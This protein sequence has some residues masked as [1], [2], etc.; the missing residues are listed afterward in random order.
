MTVNK[1]GKLNP[2]DKEII[3]QSMMADAKEQFG[4]DLNDDEYAVIRFFYEPVAERHAELQTDLRDV[5]ESTQLRYATGGA[6]D[7]VCEKLGIK[8]RNALFSKGVT[9]FSRNTA[10]TVD[11]TIPSGTIIQTDSVDPYRF[12]TTSTAILPAGQTSVD[13]NIKAKNSGVKYNVGANT[14]T[15]M[16]SPPTGIESVT[17]PADTNDGTEK[18]TDTEL[19]RRVKKEL[20][21]GSRASQEALIRAARRVQG[22]ENASIFVN[23]QDPI[24]TVDG[25][26]PHEVEMV[27]EGGNSNEIAQAL[28]NT[29]AAGDILVG[30]VH[31]VEVAEAVSLSNGQTT[32]ISYSN[33]EKV[34]IY[35][36]VD[37]LV[38]NEFSDKNY[39]KDSIVS[40]IGGLFS[41]GNEDGG[42]LSVGDNVIYGQVE[43]SVRDV[44]GVFDINSLTVGTTASPSKTSNISIEEFQLS[45]TNALD[46]SITVTTNTI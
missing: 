31:G 28:F 23:D 9:R 17:N 6:L 3:L 14:L 25:L 13:V 44:N 15:V 29:K 40:Y 32:Q 19:R 41:S 39:I 37:V 46:E 8:R 42:E 12:F 35:I 38:T 18:E 30:G 5:L 4:S 34:Q 24:N 36:D 45:I 16:P 21:S 43:Y 1:D 26:E 22:V 20:G 10:A 33:P 7:L 11:Y 2:D 27:I